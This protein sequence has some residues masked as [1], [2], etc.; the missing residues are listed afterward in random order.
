MIMIVLAKRRDYGFVHGRN[1]RSVSGRGDAQQYSKHTKIRL[2][3][4]MPPDSGLG[5][6]GYGAVT[7]LI[8]CLF[9]EALTYSRC[10]VTVGFFALPGAVRGAVVVP[11][12]SAATT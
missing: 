4:R 11:R 5:R 6:H 8:F 12:S 1:E 9:K 10:R 3:K 2:R 7:K